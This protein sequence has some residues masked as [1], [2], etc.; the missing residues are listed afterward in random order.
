MGVNL[1]GRSTRST[2]R[3]RVGHKERTQYGH[4]LFH[5][6]MDSYMAYTYEGR[7]RG[8]GEMGEVREDRFGHA[9]GKRSDL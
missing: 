9:D 8:G 7:Q 3:R 4:H 6:T 5:I 2:G 1:I